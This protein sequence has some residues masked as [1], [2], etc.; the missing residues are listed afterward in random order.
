MQNATSRPSSQEAST[1]SATRPTLVAHDARRLLRLP[2]HTQLDLA[3][4]PDG[5][6]NW[7]WKATSGQGNYLLKLNTDQGISH[8]RRLER[9][10][11]RAAQAGVQVPHVDRVGIDPDIGPFLV[12]SW[13][14]G[15]TLS[16]WLDA[17]G[18]DA[19]DPLP[20]TGLGRQI[21]LLHSSDLVGVRAPARIGRS[22]RTR[23]LRGMLTEAR[24]AGLLDASLAEATLRRATTL[25][26]EMVDH[27]PVFCHL[28]IHPRN[29]LVTDPGAVALL[30]FDHARPTDPVYDFV[31]VQMWCAQRP[32]ELRLVLDG[33]ERTRTLRRDQ[34]FWSA[35]AFYRMVNHLSY[36]LY[37]SHRDPSHVGEWIAAVIKEIETP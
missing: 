18:A 5:R 17:G 22:T 27:E 4:L 9:S 8:L 24:R 33:Y 20:W 11:R 12:Q 30:D 35:L 37:W 31:K 2:R 29:V 6:F 32:E 19:C 14:E 34:S 21:G 7:C 3:E 23:E 25:L 26:D 13:L 15:Q 16:D 36:C 1:L 10:T 28:D